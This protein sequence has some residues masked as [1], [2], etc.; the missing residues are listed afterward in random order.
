MDLT[1]TQSEHDALDEIEGMTA[2][3]SW[4]VV[5]AVEAGDICMLT[6][7]VETSR[8]MQRTVAE[9]INADHCPPE[10]AAVLDGVYAK[11]RNLL[12]HESAVI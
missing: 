5:L 8:K 6:G 12:R 3:F 7:N 4:V 2:T 11:T 9:E 1:L 10:S